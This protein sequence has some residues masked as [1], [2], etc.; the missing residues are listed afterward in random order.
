MNFAEMCKEI[1]YYSTI[2][3]R[4]IEVLSDDHHI[5]WDFDKFNEEQ[6]YRPCMI[7][8]EY[9]SIEQI[10]YRVVGHVISIEYNTVGASVKLWTKNNEAVKISL[11]SNYQMQFGDYVQPEEQLPPI[12]TF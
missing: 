11:F 10:K 7:W 6:L 4:N 9:D 3:S 5:N 12:F 1:Q 2:S 8:I